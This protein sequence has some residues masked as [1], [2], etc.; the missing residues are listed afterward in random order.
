M[1]QQHLQSLHH[2]FGDQRSRLSPTLIKKEWERVTIEFSWKSS[3]IEGNTYSLIDTENLLKEGVEATGKTK[4][5]TK[6]ILNH[7]SALDFVRSNA[8]EFKNIDL[9]HLEM[10]HGIL[11]DDLGVTIGL[12]KN[13]VGITGTRY[14]PLDNE[15]QIKEAV[16]S[17]CALINSKVSHFDKSL[18]A[19]LLISYIQPFED[20]NKRTAR[21]IANAILNAHGCFPMS[22]RSTNESDYKKAILIFYEVNNISAF[23]K[24]FIKQ[25]DFSVANYFRDH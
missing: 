1:E 10:V 6:M 25:C 3:A 19:L 24:I 22:F 15:F 7:K 13:L 5:E 23:K 14:R 9:K 20:G 21:L 8:N 2:K 11:V 4:A 12:R 16:E 18:L 17:T